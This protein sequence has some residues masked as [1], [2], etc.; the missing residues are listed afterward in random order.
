VILW[1]I[2]NSTITKKMTSAPNAAVIASW[3]M[4]ALKIFAAAP[5]R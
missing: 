4:I 3:K 2:P 1:L 5:T